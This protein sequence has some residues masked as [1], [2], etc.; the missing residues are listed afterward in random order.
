M[1]ARIKRAVPDARLRL[2]GRFSDA[3][4]KPRESTSIDL[5]GS[6]IPQKRSRP[7]P[8]W[9]YPCT[10]GPE[11]AARSHMHSVRNALSSRR[12]WCLRLRR[13]GR[14]A[15]CF[16]RSRRKTSP[17]A[18][19][20]T[21]RHPEVAAAMAEEAWQQFLGKWTWE[22]IRPNVWAAAEDCLE[23]TVTFHRTTVIRYARR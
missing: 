11:L 15:T 6:Q 12:A 2:I 5:A 8:P 10:S 23:S 1:L 9:S 4:L 7:G 22:A 17:K 19:I 18:C 3:P 16:W 21:I 14:S 20:R 13:E